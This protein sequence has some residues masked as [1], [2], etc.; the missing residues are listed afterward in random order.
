MQHAVTISFGLELHIM[1]MP[2]AA[3]EETICDCIPGPNG[4]RHKANLLRTFVVPQ[5][6]IEEHSSK[7]KCTVNILAAWISDQYV[8]ILVDFT[9]LV[10]FHVFSQVTQFSHD[11]LYPE[12]KVCICLDIFSSDMLIICFTLLNWLDMATTLDPI[13][14]WS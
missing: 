12:L 10:C 11:E 14:L 6:F 2:Q 5:Q 9:H 8:W 4:N 3:Y 7:R 13:C 1:G